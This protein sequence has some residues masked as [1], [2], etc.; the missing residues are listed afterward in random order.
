MSTLTCWERLGSWTAVLREKVCLR[1]F[2][3]VFRCIQIIV[4]SA[5][6]TPHLSAGSVHTV[7]YR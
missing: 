2:V 5:G 3:H 4:N 7:G 1:F 6:G